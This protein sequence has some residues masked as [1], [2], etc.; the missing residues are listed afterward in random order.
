MI[1]NRLVDIIAKLNLPHQ[2]LQNW[3]ELVAKKSNIRH[4]LEYC[5]QTLIKAK[6][7]ILMQ[8]GELDGCS[9]NIFIS[10]LEEGAF[11]SVVNHIEDSKHHILL[12]E[13]NFF[14]VPSM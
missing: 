11:A 6:D 7:D 2:Y 1:I 14:R 10:T 13:L 8:L 12:E 4:N 9:Y 3:E 5:M